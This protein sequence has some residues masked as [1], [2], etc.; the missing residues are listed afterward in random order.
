MAE[1][2]IFVPVSTGPQLVSEI[3]FSIVWHSGFAAS[4]KKR[5]ISALHE[6][7]EKMGYSPL[8][9]ISTKSDE[10]L[11]QRLSAFSLIIN[12]KEAGDIPLECAFQGSKVFEKGG[13]YKDLYWNDPRQAKRDAR[14][15]NSGRLIGFE[16]EELSFPVDPKTA[17]YDWL[18]I[19]AIFPYREW[20]SRLNRYS[21]FTDIEFNPKHSIN[22]QARSCA[23]F[24]A[25]RNRNL[26]EDALASPKD[27]IETLLHHSYHPSLHEPTRQNI[28]F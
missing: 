14:L 28:L 21:A 12:N 5:N 9:E 2:P 20:L 18:Y 8:L 15:Q 23:L 22:C 17:F 16:Y 11:G 1:R 4:Q 25:L 3:Y 7:A 26:L 6:A 24:L 13:P 10:K 27:F 19:T